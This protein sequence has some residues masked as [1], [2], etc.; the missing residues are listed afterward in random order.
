[1]NCEPKAEQ[2]E[3]ISDMNNIF[4]LGLVD[5]K[6]AWDFQ[7]KTFN[8][9]KRGKFTH[10]FILCQHSPVITLGRQARG[11]NILIPESELK[12]KGIEIYPVE[13]GGDATY[14]GPGQLMLYPI[15]NLNYFKRDIHIFL[16]NLEGIA[17]QTFA[18]FSV[19]TRRI[20]GFTGVW[21]ENK[22]IASIGIAIK[23]WITYHGIA[24]N[25]KQ[26][27]LSNFSLIRP[28]GMDIMMT[29]LETCIGKKIAV[30]DIKK[31]LTRRLQNGKSCFA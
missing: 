10:A 16:R 19:T 18:E 6:E 26:D 28:C 1:M 30:C 9:V 20:K 21:F 25:V 15:L 8:D 5:F 13:R 23:N 29:S 7:K 3:A 12:N 17:M 24:I 2:D 27:D 31:I 22:K 11:K 14:H 4:D